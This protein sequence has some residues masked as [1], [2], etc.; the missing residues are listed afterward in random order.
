MRVDDLMG[1]LTSVYLE[2]SAADLLQN[3]N[4]HR[5]ER[6]ITWNGGNTWTEAC[7]LFDDI[8]AW[9]S[10]GA[11]S[12][13]AFDG[14]IFRLYFRYAQS[15]ALEQATLL[16][17]HA[18]PCCEGSDVLPWIRVDCDPKRQAGTLH[19]ECHLH[20]HGAPSVRI[21]VDG[22]PTPRAF[23]EAIAAWF[24]PDKYRLH[25]QLDSDG[26]PSVDRCTGEVFPHTCSAQVQRVGRVAFGSPKMR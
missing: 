23:V 20:V 8:C 4:Y 22:L 10:A 17:V 5:R 14:S 6:E 13:Q 26:W 18:Q 3:P 24:Y 9:E 19:A 12:F 21:P 25:R 2:W 15:G 11:Y 1:Q 7:I 16:F